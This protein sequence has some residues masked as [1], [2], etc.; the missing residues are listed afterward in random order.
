M[1]LES[2]ASTA[3]W[4]TWGCDQPFCVSIVCICKKRLKIVPP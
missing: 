2:R 4:W 3:S 1:E